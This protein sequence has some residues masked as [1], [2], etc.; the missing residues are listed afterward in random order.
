MHQNDQ[1]KHQK[2]DI[3]YGSEDSNQIQIITLLCIYSYILW[4]KAS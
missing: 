1:E 4:S 2:I 3:L